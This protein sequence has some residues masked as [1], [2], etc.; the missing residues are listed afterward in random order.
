MSGSIQGIFTLLTN[1]MAMLHGDLGTD[2]HKVH[3]IFA[4]ESA[5]L[6]A[7]NVQNEVVRAHRSQAFKM[8]S[9]YV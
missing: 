3:T 1:S 4:D 7:D 8:L 6:T 2:C 9:F 5:C